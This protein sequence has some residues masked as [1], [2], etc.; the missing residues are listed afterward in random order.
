MS[1]QVNGCMGDGWVNG[2]GQVGGCV[3]ISRLVGVQVG[4]WMVDGQVGLVDKWT[5]GWVDM[6]QWVKGWMDEWLNVWVG[7]QVDAWVDIW[8]YV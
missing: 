3:D 4:R 6:Y 7:R 2:K 5:N 1:E 8:I